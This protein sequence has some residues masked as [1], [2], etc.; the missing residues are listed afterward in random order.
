MVALD[1]PAHGESP[2][3]ETSFVQSGDALGP[4][5]DE[6]QP[7]A[8]VA[9]SFGS[10]AMTVASRTREIPCIFAGGPAETME[11]LE[12]FCEFLAIGPKIRCRMVAA[13][14]KR[15]GWTLQ[16]AHVGNMAKLCKAPMLC[17]QDPLDA[18]IPFSE[19]AAIV[20]NWQGAEHRAI[21]GVGHYKIL[22]KPEAIEAIMGFL[23]SIGV[24]RS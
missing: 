14:E 21:P 18:E 5:L 4:I 20:A 23:Y 10:G 17:I 8:V 1:F 3:R 7:A 16:Q 24:A 6:L 19:T 9:H 12:R 11:I 2:G 15:L 13:T 22:W